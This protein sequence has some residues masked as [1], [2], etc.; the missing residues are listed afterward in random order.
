ME[1]IT[2]C[3]IKVAVFMGATISNESDM[4]RRVTFLN[5]V[6]SPIQQNWC[7]SSSMGYHSSWDWL[8]PVVEKIQ[9]IKLPIPSM[10]EVSVKIS[11]GECRIFKGEWNDGLEGF[12][13]RIS[14]SGNKKQYTTIEATYLCVVEFIDWYNTNVNPPL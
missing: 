14:Y 1:K 10:V 5:C 2:E 8:M 3:N 9:E 11:K 4:K 7:Y 12:I 6:W 13:N